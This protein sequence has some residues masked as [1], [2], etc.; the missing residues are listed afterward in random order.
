MAL[1]NILVAYNGSDS[2]DAAVRVAIAMHKK[3]EAHVTGILAH[4]SAKSRLAEEAW[5]PNKIKL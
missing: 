4:R 1:K 5:I 2:S 3:Y